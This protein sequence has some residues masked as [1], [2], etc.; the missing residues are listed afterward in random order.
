[1]PEYRQ[2]NRRGKSN[3]R[4]GRSEKRPL[5]PIVEETIQNVQEQLMNSIEPVILDELNGFQRKCVHHHF[6]RTDEYKVKAISLNEHAVRLIIY[7][8]GKL[9][10][11]AETRAQEVLM[12]GEPQ[13]FPPMGSFERFI[14]HDYIKTR[15]GLHTESI[16]EGNER[17]IKV[18]PI[19]G[20]TPRKVKR[21]LTR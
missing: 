21:R 20:R 7:P 2:E 8:V 14:I 13:S 9:R 12:T 19:F 1:M 11:F 10:R 5:D 4:P 17:H 6:S 15:G 16:G 18:F 3:T